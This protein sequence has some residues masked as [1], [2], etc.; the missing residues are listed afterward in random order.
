MIR[1]VLDAN[2]IASGMVRFRTGTRAPAVILRAWVVDE[3]FEL[4]ISE[5]ILDE[6][7]R[8]L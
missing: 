3:A 6:V 7:V 8:T 4:L 5:H 2:T 1:A